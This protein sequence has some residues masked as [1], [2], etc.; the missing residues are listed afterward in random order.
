MINRSSYPDHEEPA[1]TGSIT[2][3]SRYPFMSNE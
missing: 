1:L 3:R 2:T